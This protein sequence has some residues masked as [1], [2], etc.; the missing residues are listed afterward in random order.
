[1]TMT[2]DATASLE[3]ATTGVHA[4]LRIAM[5]AY[6][7]PSESKIGAGYMAHR[8]ANAVAD[9]GHHVTMYSPASRPA[10][11]RY[12][13][14]HHPLSGRGRLF[15]WAATVRDLDFSGFDALLAQGDDHLVRRDAVPVHIRT[16]HGSCLDEAVHARGFR[17]RARMAALGVTEVVAAARTPHV[18]GVSHNSIRMFPWHHTV[19]PN[20]VDTSVFH[21]DPTVPLEP[22]PT[23]LFV[24]T[25][26]RRKRGA[27]LQRVF[28]EYVLPRLPD[29]QL[30]MV[31]D[32]AP[33]APGVHVLGRLSDA[34]LADRYRRAWVFCLPST[35]EGFGVPYVEAMMS[36]T[37]V[38]ASPNPGATE[39]L[40][41]GRLGILA[42]DGDIGRELVELLLDEDRRTQL[43][44]LATL[45]RERYDMRRVA[46]AYVCLIEQ[47][48]D[49]AAPAPLVPRSRRVER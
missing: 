48:L 42:A 28:G 10:D 22:R 32:D 20:G 41:G 33:A 3:S 13:H 25:Y 34:D 45:E 24:G 36:G 26:E 38:V 6:Y 27:L 12:E 21:D 4:P 30:W 2:T 23:I 18:V 11:A 31:C 17:D 5:T 49:R 15:R 47:H 37:P 46:E 9:L 14:S 16:M 40:D 39:V 19:I 8:L 35:Y 43:G 7:L 44:G 29:A 1:V